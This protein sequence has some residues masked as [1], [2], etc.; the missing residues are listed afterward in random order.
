VVAD[1]VEGL[2]EVFRQVVCDRLWTGS[3]A[4]SGRMERADLLRRLAA[5]GADADP[6]RCVELAARL[7][8]LVPDL[9]VVAGHPVA[10][11]LLPPERDARVM[12]EFAYRA[13]FCDHAQMA[14]LVDF[15]RMPP[16]EAPEPPLPRAAPRN[17][18]WR[19][20]AS[21]LS[22]VLYGLIR[23]RGFGPREL[24]F[25]GLSQS[26]I[27]GLLSG[28][29]TAQEHRRFQLSAMAGPLGW[30]LEDLL[31]VAGEPTSERGRFVMHCHHLGQ[32]FVAAIGLTTGQLI[33]AAKQADRLSGRVNRAWRPF[34]HGSAIACP[35][36]TGVSFT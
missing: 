8:M 17:V 7:G 12:K 22:T 24:P 23:N 26:T 5:R 29:T 32:V 36:L 28:R 30:K 19:P 25:M 18:Y 13:T 9:L 33:E 27:F 34:S 6:A 11:D 14:A 31:A 2:A 20:E 4:Y 35:D 15:I 16:S 1:S 3:L 10:G 21:Y